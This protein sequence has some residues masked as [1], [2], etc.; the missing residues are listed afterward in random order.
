MGTTDTGFTPSSATRGNINNE[1]TD[2]NNP[3]NTTHV[4]ATRLPAC[5]NVV[6]ASAAI[7]RLGQ[8]RRYACASPPV[9]SQRR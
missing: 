5:N 9:F 6:A 3:L 8:S 2:K 4:A 1:I 7:V